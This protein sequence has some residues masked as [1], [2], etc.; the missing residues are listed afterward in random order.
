MPKKFLRGNTQAITTIVIVVIIVI[1]AVV[2]GIGVYIAT[3]GSGSHPSTSPT[4][5]PTSSTVPSSTPTATPT[6]NTSPIAIPTT[7]I[8]NANS[9][10]YNATETSNTGAFVATLYYAAKNLNN[11]NIEL[12]WVVTTPSTGTVEYIANGI[13][14]TAWTNSNGQWTEA[15]YGNQLNNIQLEAY[16]Y[17][18]L[19]SG[20]NN[21]S[22]TFDAKVPAG[23]PDAGNTVTFT[24]IQIN[25]SL[26]DSLFKP[27]T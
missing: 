21:G 17:T 16:G 23:E 25:P 19:L 27:P 10:E 6:L 22:G 12:L 24:N 1:A 8:G 9:Y 18:N 4:S 14:Q 5:I 20:Y 15:S 26:P 7:S 2:I 3:R 11:S 13:Q